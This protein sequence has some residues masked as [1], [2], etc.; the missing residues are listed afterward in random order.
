M[1]KIE[2]VTQNHTLCSSSIS[3]AVKASV[4]LKRKVL[5]C[6]LFLLFYSFFWGLER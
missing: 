3:I 4:L 6:F 1:T 5:L 2:I